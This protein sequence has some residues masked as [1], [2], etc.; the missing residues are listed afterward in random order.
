SLGTLLMGNV[1][2]RSHHQKPYARL[3]YDTNFLTHDVARCGATVACH[4]YQIRTRLY[5]RSWLQN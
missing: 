1:G 5:N 4:L 2:Y 3:H